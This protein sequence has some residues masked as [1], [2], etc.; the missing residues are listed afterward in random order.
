MSDNGHDSEAKDRHEDASDFAMLQEMANEYGRQQ[1]PLEAPP[2]DLWSRI[3]STLAV[4]TD[5]EPGT[6]TALLVGGLHPV[7]TTPSS[8]RTKT[9][10]IKNPIPLLIAAAFVVVVAVGGFILANRDASPDVLAS[11]ELE[12]LT[13]VDPGQAELIGANGDMQLRLTTGDFDLGESFAEVWLINTDVTA[14]ISLGPLRS[15]GV[16]ELP[17]GLNPEDFPIVDVSFEPFDGDPTHSGDSVLRG[18]FS[19]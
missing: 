3:E 1:V 12:A 11:A 13:E 16:Y 19:F 7:Q 17:T 6:E 15:D 8:A 14:L 9:P 4:E 18:Q 5:D 2:A 10:G